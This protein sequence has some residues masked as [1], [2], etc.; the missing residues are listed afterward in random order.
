ML[1]KKVSEDTRGPS[2]IEVKD[3]DN[4][5]QYVAIYE[6]LLEDCIKNSAAALGHV[7]IN[8]TTKPYN[9]LRA[10]LDPELTE[11]S[12]CPPVINSEEDVRAWYG[13]VLGQPAVLAINAMRESK[14]HPNGVSQDVNH[15][16]WKKMKPWT[17]SASGTPSPI[18]D[19]L[20]VDEVRDENVLATDVGSVVATV[21]LK[22]ENSYGKGE[23]FKHLL[24][25]Q[26]RYAAKLDDKKLLAFPFA[27][28]TK[29]DRPSK[30]TSGTPA[31]STP[32][33]PNVPDLD[34]PIPRL[35]K[36]SKLLLQVCDTQLIDIL[37]VM[38]RRTHPTGILPDAHI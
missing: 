14:K 15:D 13:G 4:A 3:R 28:P 5:L 1:N 38:L 32:L 23:A 26:K 34:D 27:W 33:P 35:L 8:E 7:E 9:P 20:I 25:Q 12:G 22:T 19:L 31:A 6:E 11:L 17:A 16:S 10:Y 30:S 29:A 21:E 36:Q 18:P 2:S 24:E 37:S